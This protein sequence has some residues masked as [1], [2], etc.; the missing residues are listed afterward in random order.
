M[1]Y[2][3]DGKIETEYLL[4]KYNSEKDDLRERENEM[5]DWLKLRGF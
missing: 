1:I 4:G 3:A 5:N 2:L